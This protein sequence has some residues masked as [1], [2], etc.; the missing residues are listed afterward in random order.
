MKEKISS[1]LEHSYFVVMTGEYE[2]EYQILIVRA[3]TVNPPKI[4]LWEW[5]IMASIEWQIMVSM[6]RQIRA[7]HR[8]PYLP[9]H[10]S[11][12]LPFH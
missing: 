10:G 6:E 2:S 1:V 4:G 7:F 9:F 5:Q 3:L 11:P 12:Y 8:S